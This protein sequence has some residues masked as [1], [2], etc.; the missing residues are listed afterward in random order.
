MPLAA[1]VRLVSF[2]A[3]WAAQRAAGVSMI[4]LMVYRAEGPTV[5]A[6]AD[7]YAMRATEARLP[8]TYSPFAAPAF[9][10]LTLLGVPALRAPATAASLGLLITAVVRMRNGAGNFP[11]GMTIKAAAVFCAA[12]A[13]AAAA[14][15]HDSLRFWTSMVFETGRVGHAEDTADQSLRGVLARL[16]HTGVPGPWWAAAA[17]LTAA[18]G[19]AVAVC[20]EL[21][22]ERAWAA[23]ACAV[24]ALLVSPVS[25]S[26]HWVWCVP[27]VVLALS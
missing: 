15:P 18:L 8:T 9:T 19:L 20:A 5:R 2:A 23:M 25:W 26:H 3:F 11:L 10:P 6:G 1:A 12:T 14:L 21:L 7:L 27:V 24:T 17:A 16:F 22:G 13:T 4:D